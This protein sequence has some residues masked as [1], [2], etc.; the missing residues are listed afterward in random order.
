MPSQFHSP[1][2]ILVLI[3]AYLP[4]F[5]AFRT[6]GL[7]IPVTR[8]NGRFQKR[9]SEL[10]GWARAE[11]QRVEDRYDLL[12][13]VDTRKRRRS[14][15]RPGRRGLGYVPL[16]NALGQ[17]T[18]FYGTVQVGTPPRPFNVILDTGSS[19][20]WLASSE[21]ANCPSAIPKFDP[22]ASSSAVTVSAQ[23]QF[24]IT[25]G[26][27]KA[28]GNAYVE[29]VYIGGYVVKGTT[30]AAVTNSTGILRSN[31]PVSGIMGLGFQAIS[32]LGVVPV[33]E[34][35]AG[36]NILEKPVFGFALE[37]S[38][39]SGSPTWGGVMT[40]GNTNSSLFVGD[41]AYT[42]VTAST[43]WLIPLQGISVNTVQLIG[44]ET[45]GNAAIDTGTSLI[46]APQAAIDLIFSRIPG[47]EAGTGDF[48]GYTLY[49]CNATFVLSL[50]FSQTA[51]PINPATFNL[52][53]VGDGLCLAPFFPISSLSVSAAFP[54]WIIG[55]S[56]L[57]GV[58]SVFR[59]SPGPAVGFAALAPSFTNTSPALIQTNQNS[60]ESSSTAIPTQTASRGNPSSGVRMTT[61][62]GSIRKAEWK[63]VVLVLL[64]CLALQLRR[65]CP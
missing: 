13:S 43:Y 46:G 3:S 49:P 65:K 36:S 60:S 44:E 21:C 51:F 8:V 30:I 45:T 18:L 58:Y 48:E 25:Y 47:S 54:Q 23:R 5:H 63:S 16:V 35:L 6:S 56:F 62:G 34:L 53:E 22:L 52:G 31:L 26:S 61:S 38:F 20:F 4:V 42:N 39:L 12:P 64:T 24:S 55:D 37:S 19:D 11:L 50:T 15:G 2:L 1:F 17:D 29:N 7:V 32:S 28:S 33:W 59:S 27:G 9:G 41:I 40:L 14:N 10:G 57:L